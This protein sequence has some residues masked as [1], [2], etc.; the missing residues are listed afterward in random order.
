[1]SKHVTR[2]YDQFQPNSYEL[3][4]Q[5]NKD[6]MTFTGRVTVTGKKV[7]RPSQR[8]T[9]HQKG[10]TCT[11]ATI[12]KHDKQG[13]KTVEVSRINKQDSL[14]ELRLHTDEKLYPGNYS[15]T[16]EFGSVI[17]KGMT[18]LYPCFFTADGKDQSL[19]ATQ[20]ESHHAREVFP[21]IDEP[22]AKATFDLSLTAPMGEIVL[23]NTPIKS[24]GELDGKQL[25]H[26]VTTPKMSV[27]LL[28]FVIGNLHAKHTQTKRGTAVS[29]WA[30]VAQPI[31][32]LSYA[33]EVAKGSIEFFEDYFGVPYPLAKADHVALPD[34][35]S[36]AME[37]WGLIT[38][39]ERVMLAYPGDTS[40]SIKETIALVIAHETSHQWFGNLVTMR[41]WNDLWLNESFANMMEYQ[42]V[43]A[44]YPDWQVWDTFVAQE[45]LSSLR[46]DATPGVQS[47]RTAVNHPDEISTL[48]DPSIVYAKGGR[49]LYM[50][51]TYIGEDAFR[52]GLSD[53]FNKHAYGNT[54]GSD[55]WAA[56][57]KAS[58]KDV[59]AFMNPWLERPGFPVISVSQTDDKLTISQTHFSDNP[60]KA[61]PDRLWPVP[62][63]ASEAAVPA[64][65]QKQQETVTLKTNDIGLINTTAS[66]HYLVNYTEPAQLAE[67]TKQIKSGKL[68][69]AARLMALNDS[70]MLARAGHQTYAAVLTLLAAY[71][72]ETSEPVWDIM[73]VVIGEL[74]RFVDYDA[75]LEGSIKAAVQALVASEYI[76]LG[77][78]EIVGESAA[79]Q[80]QRA[81]ILGLGAYAEDPEIVKTAL[82][83]FEAAKKTG[84]VSLPSELRAIIYSVP[85]KMN[86]DGAVDYLIQQHDKTS[87]SDLQS[88]IAAALTTTREINVAERLLTRIKDAKLIKP[89]DADRWLVYLIRNRFVGDTAWQWMVDNWGWLEE[90]YSQDKSYDYLPR[91]A[92]SACNT[93]AAAERF[94]AF[95]EPKQDQITLQRNILMGIE[96]ITN[97]VAWLERDL[98][99]VQAYFNK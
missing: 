10:L 17:T 47:V 32:S 98:P 33:L 56:L 66:G 73:S 57:S 71:A 51:K 77:W 29:T 23:G 60:A 42:A 82:A 18:G 55:L 65:L 78:D 75:A 35:S 27:Y 19:L 11:S 90:T 8:L 22:E 79:D 50:L 3:F 76:R 44:L 28:A 4:L 96:E 21:C 68:S 43:D 39:R 85:V 52:S 7:G 2:L 38:Y 45:G 15:I 49:L 26:F 58:G 92:A 99:A 41:W 14:N 86:I 12:V 6:K 1:M 97:R 20:F 9:F 13:D 67:V 64:L 94:Q 53:Y 16:M 84:P 81:T 72:D 61:D 46:R 63:F 69:V 37:N 95:F 93:S 34:F 24:S 25:V 70:S 74:R 87:N 36:G 91:Y 31:E 54:E 5:P 62:L 40:Q 30:T 80:K 48:F 89:Q 88:D 59:G 83:K